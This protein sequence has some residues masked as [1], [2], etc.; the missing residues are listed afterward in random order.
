MGPM[1]SEMKF[2]QIL[3]IVNF[4]KIDGNYV[5]SSGADEWSLKQ[6]RFSGFGC[7]FF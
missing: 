1:W 2:F 3:Y 6:N 5:T 7:V 4:S